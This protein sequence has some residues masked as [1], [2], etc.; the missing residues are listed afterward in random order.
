AKALGMGYS[1]FGLGV[2]RELGGLEACRCHLIKPGGFVGEMPPRQR[3]LTDSEIALV[4][5]A[6]QGEFRNG[7]ESTYPAGPFARLLLLTAVRR[8]EGAHM[9]WDE[10]NLDD[11]LW[12]L[13]RRRTKS[14]SR[15]EVPLPPMAVDLLRSLPRFGGGDFVFS[16][17]GGRAP[18]SSFAKFKDIIA[19]RAAELAPPGLANWRFHDLRRTARTNLASLGVA[20]FIA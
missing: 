11:A 19:A 9:T 20:T 10:G 5:Q 12:V 16:T 1:M 8:S 2:M 6:T 4:W 18:I 3:V 17:K 13:P 7:I 15:H 14:G